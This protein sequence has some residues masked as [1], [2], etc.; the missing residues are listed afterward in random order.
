MLCSARVRAAALAVTMTVGLAACGSS[1]GSSGGSPG[2]GG[3]TESG[4]NGGNGRSGGNA[5]AAA[6]NSVQTLPAFAGDYTECVN[7]S[8]TFLRLVNTTQWD[9]FLLRV[10][11]GDAVPVLS[12]VPPQGTSLADLVVREQ[13]PGTISGDYA[14]LAP[15]GG[16][17]TATALG[18]TPIHLTIGVDLPAVAAN[19]SAIG[20]ADVVASRVNPT[21]A[22]AQAIVAC[23][24]YVRSLPQQDVQSQPTAAQFWN[25]FSGTTECSDAFRTASDALGLS[26][27]DVNTQDSDILSEVESATSDFFED[28][29]PKLAEVAT[30]TLFH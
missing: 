16:T 14:V 12:T 29:L 28:V 15:E 6:C 8:D 10:P 5:A 27:D 20:L 2:N 18:G 30:E 26:G 3:S 13:F 21:Q 25:D 24:D 11:E 22:E 17:L 7:S 19:V 4:G 1:G 9:V 23:S